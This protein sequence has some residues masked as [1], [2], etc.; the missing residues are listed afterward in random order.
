MK[1]VLLLLAVAGTLFASGCGEGWFGGN[2]VGDHLQRGISGEGKLGPVTREEGDQ[3]NEHGVP[4][5]HP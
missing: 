5:T 4:Q 1:R 3:A 2:E